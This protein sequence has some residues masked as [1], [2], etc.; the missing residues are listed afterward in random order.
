MTDNNTN[1][2]GTT[3]NAEIANVRSNWIR[4]HDCG[5]T[6]FIHQRHKA[7][8]VRKQNGTGRWMVS[9]NRGGGRWYS[10]LYTAMIAANRDC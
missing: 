1:A 5:T 2:K 4:R 9:F 10:C 7:E 3:M 6:Y 8:I